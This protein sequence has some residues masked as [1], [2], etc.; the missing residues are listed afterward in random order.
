MTLARHARHEKLSAHLASRNDLEALVSESGEVG[1][2]GG[3][4]ATEST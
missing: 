3:S 1:V 2:G 4:T